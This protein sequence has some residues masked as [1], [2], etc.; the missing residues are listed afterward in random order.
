MKLTKKDIRAKYDLRIDL[1]GTVPY[2]YYFKKVGD[3]V[4]LFSKID[5][6][7]WEKQLTPY[8]DVPFIHFVDYERN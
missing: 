1:K 5:G 6:G 8:K 4:Y 3:S 2:D 7:N